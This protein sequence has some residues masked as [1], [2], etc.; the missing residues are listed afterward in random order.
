MSVRCFFD[1]DIGDV[2]EGRIVFELFDDLIPNTVEN[3]RALC[4]GEKGIGK[5]GYP[6]H[7]KG[8]TFHRVIKGFMIQGGDFTRGDGTGGESIYGDKFDDESFDVKHDE[9]F[10]LSMANAGPNTNGSQFFITTGKATHLDDKHVIFGIVLKGKSV[11]RAIEN[12]P[13]GTNDKPIKKVTIVDCGELKENE[14]DGVPVPADGDTYEDWPEDESGSLKP[15]KLLEIAQ[16]VKDIGNDYFKKGDYLNASKKYTKA[17]RYLNEKTTFE[18]DDPPELEKKF[19]SLKISCYLNKAACSLKLQ[20]WKNAVDDTTI[21]LEMS[22]EY[23]LDADKA[24]ALY[25]RGSAKVGMKDEEE[26][27]K[28]LQQALKLNP[29]DA[30][31]AKEIAIAK[32]KLKARE[33]K[34]K[35]AFAKMFE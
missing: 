25:R 14:D 18:D 20:N 22:P 10:L 7:Y 29:Q 15:E 5:S 28:D 32:Q 13:T 1:I 9:P 16:K 27:V 6:L 21:V 8:S 12:N 23:L 30:A 24:K 2:R 11:V 31:I 33:E 17:I 19:Y 35:K 4:T 34:Q 3:F 26:A